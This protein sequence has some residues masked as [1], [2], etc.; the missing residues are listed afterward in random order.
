MATE[1]KVADLTIFRGD[2]DTDP[3]FI[4]VQANDVDDWVCFPRERA[5]EVIEAVR[6]A[7]FDG[8]E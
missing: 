8:D 5:P 4:Y 2:G 7:V 3:R 6:A 1:R